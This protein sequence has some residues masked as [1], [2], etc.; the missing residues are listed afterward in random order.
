MANSDSAVM[1]ADTDGADTPE[2]AEAIAAV[3]DI[4]DMLQVSAGGTVLEKIIG[5]IV[6]AEGAVYRSAYDLGW[7]HCKG[8]TLV[9]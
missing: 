3:Y 6:S 7:A 2:R 8:A 5:R 1:W 4:L 9:R